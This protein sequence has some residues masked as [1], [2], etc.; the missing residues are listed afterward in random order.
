MSVTKVAL[1]S[2]NTVI[3]LLGKIKLISKASKAK[4]VENQEDQGQI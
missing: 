4:A 1:R 2:K 3:N